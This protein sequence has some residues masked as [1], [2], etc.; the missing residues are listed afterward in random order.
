MQRIAGPGAID[1]LFV[2]EDTGTGQP[3]TQITAAWMN[4]VQ[5][6][7]CTVIT[8]AGL[9]LDGGDNTQL[10]AAIAA[11]ITAGST[12]GRVVPIG[13]VI[14]WSGAISAIPAHW[15]LCDV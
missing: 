11:L 8:E 5:E 2:E 9:T 7:L 15:V 12:G 14:A 6:E 4:T 13:S 1:G 3:P 10:L